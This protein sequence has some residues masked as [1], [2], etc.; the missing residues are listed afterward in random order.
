MGAV[1][2]GRQT[3]NSAMSSMSRLTDEVLPAGGEIADFHAK[4]RRAFDLMQRTERGIREI[5]GD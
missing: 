5:M 2:A 3:M 1:A 4:K